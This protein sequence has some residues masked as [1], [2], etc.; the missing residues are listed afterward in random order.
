M[1]PDRKLDVSIKIEGRILGVSIVLQHFTCQAMIIV[2]LHFC[3]CN[4]SHEQ[5]LV[6]FSLFTSQHIRFIFDAKFLS[7]VFAECR[8]HETWSQLSSPGTQF[9]RLQLCVF[10]K[11]SKRLRDCVETSITLCIKQR[12]YSSFQMSETTNARRPDKWPKLKL[13]ASN[14][15][16]SENK[17]PYPLLHSLCLSATMLISSVCSFLKQSSLE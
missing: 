11:W 13:P 9:F 17:H 1:S 12:I 16:I 14:G 3:S 4:I 15:Q 5:Q 6:F 7:V 8:I 10:L 2:S